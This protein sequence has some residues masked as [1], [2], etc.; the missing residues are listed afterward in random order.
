MSQMK[1]LYQFI[2]LETVRASDAA[3]AAAV[4]IDDALNDMGAHVPPT[5][6]I[7]KAVHQLHRAIAHLE[8]A[9][10]VRLAVSQ[11]TDPFDGGLR[12]VA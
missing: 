9:Q 4:A 6:A 8:H 5:D 2:Q 10:G 7:N 1:I 11:E 3:R 12:V